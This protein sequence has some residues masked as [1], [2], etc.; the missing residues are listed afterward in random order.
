MSQFENSPASTPISSNTPH[1][2]S[3][4]SRNDRSEEISIVD[5]LASVQELVM[6]VWPLRDYVAVN[7]FSGFSDR[8]FSAT[9]RLLRAV[10]DCELLMPLEYYRKKREKGE[11]SDHHIE[12]AFLELKEDH[13][14]FAN[15]LM[16][17]S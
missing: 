11:L 5:L 6:P 8:K 4:E 15:K 10:S 17:L 1:D 3:L 7:P 14:S 2:V 13:D 12:Q 9:R 16:R